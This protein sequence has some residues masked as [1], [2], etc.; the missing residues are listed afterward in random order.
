MTFTLTT[1]GH[2]CVRLDR[3]GGRLVIDPGGFS[4]PAVL[5]GADAV[6][7]T[8]EHADHVDPAGLAGRLVADPALEAWAP[9]GVVDQLRAAGAP[10]ART[11]VAEVGGSWTAA[12]FAVRGVGGTHRAIHP[13][14]PPVQNIGYLVEGVLLH[15]GDALQPPPAGTDLAV[16]LVPVAGPWLALADAIDYLRA[17]RPRVAVPIHDAILSPPGLA[18]A[19]RL[20]GGLGALEGTQYLRLAPGAAH[21]VEG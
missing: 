3:D 11:H 9:A 8:H 1:G 16:L 21:L 20:V 12:G 6:L 4:D 15:P 19:D 5:D 2:A 10:G 14:L 18:L 7:V 13:D 17:V